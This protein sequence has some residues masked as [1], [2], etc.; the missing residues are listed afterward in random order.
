MNQPQAANQIATAAQTEQFLQR[1]DRLRRELLELMDQTAARSQEFELPHPAEQWKPIYEKLRQ[2]QFQVLVM[3]EVKRGKTSLVNAL[4]G[5]RVL[6]TD[7]AEATCQVF[8][9]TSGPRLQCRVVYEDGHHLEIAPEE[10]PKYGSQSFQEQ[11]KKS[12]GELPARGDLIRWIEVQVPL[13][14]LPE[15]VSLLDTPGLGALY[16]QHAM[17]T[18]RYVPQAEGV[19]FVLESEKP[20]TENE[21]EALEDVLEVTRNIL[22]VQTKIDQRDQQDWEQV[23]QRN[24]EILQERFGEKLGQEVAIWP[25]SST[26][27]FKG[28]DLE[29]EAVLQASGF[30]RFAQ[31]LRK[32]L[33]RVAGW[34]QSYR[35]WK[36]VGNIL[37]NGKTA[38][39]ERSRMVSEESE[40][41]L[42]QMGES[43]KESLRKLRD[44]WGP[45]GKKYTSLLSHLERQKVACQQEINALF[46]PGGAIYRELVG[47]I[48]ACSTREELNKLL[49][50]FKQRGY[51][52]KLVINNIKNVIL[53][54][55]GYLR[56]KWMQE[57]GVG[58]TEALPNPYFPDIPEI[59]MEKDP[60][61]IAPPDIFWAALRILVNKLWGLIYI[62]EIIFGR[63]FGLERNKQRLV[64]A[65]QSALNETKP[66]LFLKQIDLDGRSPIE[67]NIE[68]IA[69]FYKEKL[70]VVIRE[71]Q[72][73]IQ[74]EIEFLQEQ[75][76]ATIQQRQQKL[77]Q[78][79]RQLQAWQELQKQHA[80]LGQQLQELQ[81][82]LA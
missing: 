82:A 71:N 49:E 16:Y 53:K 19:I 18:Y 56:K 50:K 64:Q 11:L 81:A 73:R 61:P 57:I 55:E 42:Q 76:N 43:L 39:E 78:L 38:L 65:V 20:I 32:F 40:Q 70:D 31:A 35:T 14:F 48:E 52:P 6:P 66:K 58:I 21:L 68:K 25:L 5:R 59:K 8:R 24:R 1:A 62:L 41:K 77:E 33:Y 79:T 12:D 80:Q 27:L 23:L 36:E 10:L 67:D 47:G 17:I 22:F 34:S 2:N 69:D 51:L 4:I 7:V 63:V 75:R 3:G 46:L 9:I 45:S 37:Q 30:P 15:N 13:R 60:P 54:F 44:E 29:S 28:L 72:Q 26:N 74:K